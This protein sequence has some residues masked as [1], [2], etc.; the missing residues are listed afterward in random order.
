MEP[1]PVVLEEN[2]LAF[3]SGSAPTGNLDFTSVPDPVDA[4]LRKRMRRAGSLLMCALGYALLTSVI[5]VVMAVLRLIFLPT[6]AA[7]AGVRF[8][9]GPGY[10]VYMVRLLLRCVWIAISVI[11]PGIFVFL[12]GR[13]MQNSR[14]R[15]WMI[16]GAINCILLGLQGAF[17]CL[18]GLTSLTPFRSEEVYPVEQAMNE[19]LFWFDLCVGFLFFIQVAFCGFA[20]IRVLILVSQ[21]HTAEAIDASAERSQVARESRR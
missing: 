17:G 5:S 4:A 12:G 6:A 8:E 3:D 11:L 2:P 10:G 16:T 21:R 18:N 15:G 9:D 14:S 7:Y 13:A 19:D 20:G 1:P